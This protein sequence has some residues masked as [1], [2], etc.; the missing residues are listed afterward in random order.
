MRHLLTASRRKGGRAL[1]SV[2]RHFVL[3][4]GLALVN[5]TLWAQDGKPADAAKVVED[6][7]KVAADAAKAV[8]ATSGKSGEAAEDGKAS[9]DVKAAEEGKTAGAAAA[10]P[11]A[12]KNAAKAPAPP[13][14]EVPLSFANADIN[15]IVKWLGQMTG[16]SII[17]HKEVKCQ[18][19][20]MS[21]KKLPVKTALNQVY[22]AL[23]LEG[24][25][26][27]ELR[28]VL[29]I[30]P[31]ALEAEVGAELLRS[32]G[33]EAETGRA[34]RFRPFQLKHVKAKDIQDK[35][36]LVLSKIAKVDVDEG[37]NQLI[38]M[39]YAENLDL[40]AELLEQIDVVNFAE[41]ST[42]FYKLEHGDAETLA[43]V[44]EKVFV[45]QRGSEGE[46]GGGKS[47][48]RIVPDRINNRLIVKTTPDLQPEVL[49]I[50]RELDV[51]KPADVTVRTLELKHVKARDLINDIGPMYQKMRG[52]S[53][54][55]SIEITAHKRSNSLIV[56]SS[57]ASFDELKKL[58]EQL[59]TADAK[60]SSREIFKLE[61]ADAEDVSRQLRD[62]FE[63]D[64][65]Y[66][67]RWDDD[68][69]DEDEVKFVAN[70][71]QNT[72]IA[73][74][75]PE[76]LVEVAKMVELLDEPVSGEDLVP[77]I[78]RLKYVDAFDIEK[79]LQELFMRQ[80][81]RRRSYWDDYGYGYGYSSSRSSRNDAGRLQG[82][83]R[84]TSSL[85]TNSLIIT[86]NS[87][88]S[89]D[90]VQA[91]LDKLDQPSGTD[92]TLNLKLRHAQAVTVSNNLNILFAQGGAPPVRARPQNNNGNNRRPDDG[93]STRSG[94]QLENEI[95]EDAYFPWLGGGDG[96]RRGSD[97][98]AGTRP[99]SDLVGKVRIVPDQ[100]TNSLMVTTSAHFFPQVLKVIEDLDIPTPQVLIEATIIEVASDARQRLGVR[101]SPDGGAVFESEDLENSF[102]GGVSAEFSEPFMASVLG[103]VMGNGVLNADFNLD[104]LVQF[105]RKQVDG[106]I[107]ASPR[108]NVADNE[109][110]KLF[111]G[112]RVPFIT[113]SLNTTEGGRNDSFQYRDVGIILEVTPHINRDGR[114]TLRISVESSQIRE[115]ETLFGGAIIDTRNYRTEISLEDKST[116]VLGGI[117]QREQSEVV[118]KVPLLGDIPLLGYLFK[119]KDTVH[120]EVELMVF[121]KPTVTK[122]PA[123]VEKMM[124][125]ERA[126]T[127]SIQ[128]WSQ[129]LEEEDRARREQLGPR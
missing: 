95:V 124:E 59:D 68:G 31:A 24:F 45:T 54:S 13:P 108:I 39:D 65:D 23:S 64:D 82:K 18:L 3:H 67:S 79:V 62:L 50:I 33:D 51:D 69:D 49:K 76:V 92:T 81:S 94:F 90:A 120:R 112:S 9:E 52:G 71:R 127:P 88:E 11:A 99:V 16:K 58:V 116:L 14:T 115:G 89:L 57:K 84:I 10:A 104:V 75:S 114:V 111:V 60:E 35:A 74:A 86:S 96:N 97:G 32:S 20:V 91:V 103:D 87:K 105:L 22:R 42:E 121:L 15:A 61:N 17:K 5:A 40:L 44:V 98:R 43:G 129:Q 109:R 77:L 73:S 12:D 37:S 36:K 113:G 63:S 48:V 27:L 38:V 78:Y 122:S 117:I 19:T 83:I 25:K 126:R 118:R 53:L 119:K 128:A 72:V 85:Y 123:E 46:E 110:G 41:T 80:Q 66:W 30:V 93:D 100:R 47:P 102:S 7:A 28:D 6:A 1:S 26:V 70:R 29:L 4:V 125:E 56:L 101:W 107:R 34:I 55:E 8:E 21:S 2:V 106:R